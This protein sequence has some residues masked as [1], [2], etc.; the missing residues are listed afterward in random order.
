M[1]WTVDEVTAIMA[2][3]LWPQVAI[4]ITWD[5]WGGWWDHVTPTEVEKWKDGTQFWYGGRVG[6]LVLSPH[7]RNGYVSKTPHSHVSLVKFCETNFG[8]TSLNART[9]A[10]DGMVDCFDFSQPPPPPPT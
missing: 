6:C 2:A 5:D 8:L 4:F 7:A 3:G 10:A 9:A 1:Q